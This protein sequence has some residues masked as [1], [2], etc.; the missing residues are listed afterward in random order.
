MECL[1][2]D[3]KPK[4][5]VPG[6]VVRH[7]SRLDRVIRKIPVLIGHYEQLRFG[8]NLDYSRFYLFE[9]RTKELLWRIAAIAITVLGMVAIVW[10]SNR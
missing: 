3:D 2:S 9:P 6:L 1:L 7:G 10:D 4:A 5:N 8:K